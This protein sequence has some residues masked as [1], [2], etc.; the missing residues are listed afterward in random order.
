M[1]PFNVPCV[2]NNVVTFSVRH[3]THSRWITFSR[4]AGRGLQ[5]GHNSS[6]V[7]G[8]LAER[9][10]DHTAVFL[11][12]LRSC[13]SA[14]LFSASSRDLVCT[15]NTRALSTHVH[16]SKHPHMEDV[17]FFSS[18]GCKKRCSTGVPS[19]LTDRV[20]FNGNWSLLLSLITTIVSVEANNR[21]GF[22][23]MERFCN[24]KKTFDLF[25]KKKLALMSYAHRWAA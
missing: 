13:D 18:Y 22:L 7:C 12:A 14:F 8:G 19:S 21:G 20:N 10:W 5:W 9:V 1:L 25:K 3:Q 24:T 11:W 4:G 16:G 6:A 23:G 15:C 2:E 17:G